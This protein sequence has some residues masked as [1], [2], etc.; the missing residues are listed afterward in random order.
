MLTE[1]FIKLIDR[2]NASRA[3]DTEKQLVEEFMS[4]LEENGSVTPDADQDER[5]SEAMFKHI[6]ENKGHQ[7][8]VLAQTGGLRM[9]TAGWIAVATGFFVVVSLCLFFL[10]NRTGDNT[11]ATRL[12]QTK[13]TLH[14]N[15]HMIN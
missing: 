1:R 7:I 9:K 15:Y 11:P 6:Q 3:N 10:F 12:N 8:M 14:T 4:R 13:D 2:C 5:I